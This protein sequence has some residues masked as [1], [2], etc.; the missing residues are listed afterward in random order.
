MGF[1]SRRY[2][3]VW[4]ED[5]LRVGVARMGFQL[6]ALVLGSAALSAVSL[7]QNTQSG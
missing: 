7:R 4:T 5:R 3:L 6:R 1:L 2:V